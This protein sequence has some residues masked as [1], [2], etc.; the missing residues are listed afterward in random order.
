MVRS[1]W[2]DLGLQLGILIT[3][4]DAVRRECRGNVEECFKKLLSMWLKRADP[5]PTWKALINALKSK[6][7]GFE[8]LAEKLE[9]KQVLGGCSQYNLEPPMLYSSDL[10]MVMRSVLKLWILDK[11][12]TCIQ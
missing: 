12:C 9:C 2:D 10:F 5:K 1:K 8:S 7:V 4:I 11:I 6:I 3:D